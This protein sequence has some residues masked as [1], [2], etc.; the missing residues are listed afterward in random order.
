VIGSQP[1]MRVG[2][3][4]D[5]HPFSQELD[6]PLVLGGVTFPSAPG[7]AGHSDGDVITHAIIDALLGAAGLADIGQ[8]FPDT[9]PSLEGID[10]VRL[11]ERVV[12]T[13][14]AAQW[15]PQNVDCTAVLEAPKI[16]PLRT[17]IQTRLSDA[18]GAPVSIKAKR[19]EGLGSLGRSEGVACF[20]V[21]LL[22]RA[23]AAG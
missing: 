19:A 22:T 16:A 6:R 9:D 20:A 7:L 2:H 1:I 4:F 10:S 23:G 5:V 14:G 21:A 13:I 17:A 15:A 8:Q 12:G 3:G 18:V 11:L